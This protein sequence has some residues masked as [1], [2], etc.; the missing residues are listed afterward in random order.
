MSDKT[1]FN[2]SPY[3]DD[4]DEDKNFLRILFRPGYAVQARE[5]TQ[6]QTILQK[7]VQRFGDHVFEDGSR[8]LGAGTVTRPVDFVRLDKTYTKPDGTVISTDLTKIIGYELIERTGDVN[9]RAKVV[10]GIKHSDDEPYYIAFVEFL[11]G[12][13]FTEGATLESTILTEDYVITTATAGHAE[14]TLAAN[15]KAT[16]VSVDEGV[17][18]TDGFFVKNL[19]SHTVPYN[20]DSNKYRIFTDPYAR[21]GFQI[22][23]GNVT[24]SEDE[25]LRDPSSGTYNFNAPGGDRYRIKLNLDFKQGSTGAAEEFIELLKF[26]S[27]DITYKLNKTNYSELEKT[28]ARRTYDES[29]SYTVRPFDVDPREHL[30]QGDNRGVYSEAA[31]GLE[32]KLAIGILPG[33]AYVFGQEYETQ[34]KEY[35]TIDKARNTDSFVGSFDAN[36]GNYF[37]GEIMGNANVSSP[38]AGGAGYFLFGGL[39]DVNINNAPV[40]VELAMN[41][42]LDDGN[43]PSVIAKAK[44]HK[45]DQNTDGNFRIY[46][47]DVK[48]EP[49]VLIGMDAVDSI[50]ATRDANHQG[51]GVAG[52]HTHER[53]LFKVIGNEGVG[54][55]GTGPH[56]RDQN[57]LL[58]P[59]KTGSAVKNLSSLKFAFKKTMKKVVQS[60]DT[61]GELTFT[62]DDIDSTL[63]KF[64]ATG[65]E[66]GNTDVGK[67]FI[68]KN[69]LLGVPV[70]GQANAVTIL[71]PDA[72][73]TRIDD[74]TIKV[75]NLSFDPADLGAGT[76]YILQATINCN[77]TT[78]QNANNVRRK[79]LSPISNQHFNIDGTNSTLIRNVDTN[80]SI[81]YELPHSDVFKINSIT[82]T[83]TDTDGG[84][85][86]T[87]DPSGDFLFDNGQRDN[88][89]LPARLWAREDVKLRYG[90]GFSGPS[91]TVDYEYFN[92]Q[93]GPG[94]FTVD[95]YTLNGF[96]YDDIPLYTSKN[97]RKTFSLANSLDFRHSSQTANRIP[98]TKPTSS[99]LLPLQGGYDH[100]L[101]RVDKIVIN[102]K[103][104][105]DVAFEVISGVDGI[106]PKPPADREG[107]MT[108]YS[109]TV[110]AYTHNPSDVGIKLID[111]KRYTMKDLGKVESR[112]NDIEYYTTLSL[113]ENEIDSRVI[114]TAGSTT[115]PAFKNGILV[116]G[117]RGHNIGD[118][119]HV[120]YKCSIDY[121]MGHLRPSFKPT[122]ILLNTPTISQGVDLQL[123]SDGILTF[124][125]GST[126]DYINQSSSNLLLK[127][128]PFNLANWI[129][130]VT[131][132]PSTRNWFDTSVRPNVRINTQG[133]N[134]NWKVTSV[135]NLKGY[136]TQWN[137]WESIWYGIDVVD[138]NLLDDRKGNIFLN[139]ARVKSS[140]FVIQNKTENNISS[141]TRDASTTRE[142][143]N[144]V[145]LNIR[146]LPEHLKTRIGDRIVDNSVVPFIETQ[147]ISVSANGLKPYTKVY[148]FFDGISVDAYCQDS[149]DAYG[150]FTTDI[151]GSLSDITFTVPA[152]IF[153]VGEK[154]F[155]FI[156][157]VDGVISDAIT[158]ADGV[159]YSQG[160]SRKRE[161][162]IVSTRP[163]HLRRITASSEKVIKNPYT[164]EK[165]LN[166]SKYTNWLDP[167]AQIFYVD[168]VSY[169]NG[170]FLDS[171]DLNF[172]TIDETI[173]I[174]VDIRPTFNGS[175]S[176]SVVVPFSEVYKSGT[177][178]AGITY[179]AAAATLPTQFKFTSPVFLEPGEYA[180]CLSTNSSNF[181]I[182]GGRIG[183]TSVD[184]FDRIV[185]PI[186]SGPV[187]RSSNNRTAEV[188]NT[189]ILKYNL[190]KCN[191]KADTTPEIIFQNNSISENVNID[192]YRFN[193]SSFSPSGTSIQHIAVFD[194]NNNIIENT[195]NHVVTTQ[196]LAAGTVSNMIT[197][198][199]ALNNPAVISSVSP[200]MDL[201][202]TNIIGIANQINNL[203]AAADEESAF[204]NINSATAKYISRRVTL[205]DGFESKNIKVFLD[206][207]KQGA[208]ADVSVDVYAKTSSSAEEVEFDDVGYV[209]MEVENN[210]NEFVSSNE[211]DFKEISY[212]LPISSIPLSDSDKIKSFAVK[213]CLYASNPANVPTIKDLRIVALDS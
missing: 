151:N 128:N 70:D 24:S 150:P 31:G 208:T 40:D 121:E 125:V 202:Y 174:K 100:Y 58:F 25:T 187:F 53:W 32:S 9:N 194:S 80:G 164:R 81:Y 113:L 135:N 26:D 205:E 184:G 170:V 35:V 124:V 64:D 130:T 186:Y 145:G 33:K 2:I 203:S 178:D 123:S 147:S 79:T 83:S 159:F 182:H 139:Q 78:G 197:T 129:G 5:L 85:Q 95:S 89:Y 181:E 96:T 28:L 62:L 43:T 158:S 60:S 84:D 163:V 136:G 115:D 185:L 122:E 134:D 8:V 105:E 152:S 14:D 92:H 74:V 142:E 54:P 162:S 66:S 15:G 199:F 189:L 190:N 3:Y 91:L 90:T 154:I 50:Y 119:S 165:T 37:V 112:I 76:S 104:N 106:I 211:F 192:S 198:K 23:T 34:S 72:V 155:R 75:S 131:L 138:D 206:V 168:N 110:P 67:F 51:Y 137:D 188:D 179:D 11:N 141:I 30:M 191:F 101:S 116:D 180:I 47:Y 209:K 57:T 94:P 69:V 59:L 102:N 176:P 117:F 210:S 61:I 196:T 149:S 172:G 42:N 49:D 173:P 98:D 207:N 48:F 16:L 133:E 18:Y 36:H 46:V 193:T 55:G 127:V 20:E 146:N 29:G 87:F 204:G 7:Q 126:A 167:M 169:P 17:F 160:I 103:L 12:S 161:G 166:L 73:F 45:I 144:R 201:A 157:D 71:E 4:Y 212:S 19:E 140:S 41:N 132:S 97:L 120:D 44:I 213:I 63:F 27:G 82:G 153:E 99:T 107:S 156:D 93:S 118:V 109:L 195:N 21:V 10:H 177:G 68:F 13:A 88:E 39:S 175:P 148:A 38:S 65:L 77:D 183:E 86:I 108:L 56:E 143:K 52:T 6:A 114:Y 22:T 1:I 200:V 111:N 171:V